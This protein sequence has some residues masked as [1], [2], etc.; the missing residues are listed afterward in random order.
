MA[1]EWKPHVVQQG[2]HVQ[3]LAFRHGAKPDDVWTHE[4]NKDL[5]ARRKSMDMLCPGDVLH[6][7]T[8]PAAGLDLAQGSKNR[9]RA[10]VPTIPFRLVLQTGGRSLANQP[11]EVHG[12]GGDILE[13]TTTGE[14]A[15]ELTLP[16]WVREIEIRLTELGMRFPVAIGDLDPIDEESGV[17]QRLRNLGY[18][19]EGDLAPGDLAG[20]L[21]TFQHARG[22]AE[23]GELDETTRGEL[24]TSH[25]Q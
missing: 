15:V 6:L 19:P 14:A 21:T 20:A 2:E 9:F 8:N 11:F 24:Q 12:A 1:D 23:T 16:V 3:K 13:G 7:P 22:L 10:I 5:S 18:L 17:V 4:K 25:L